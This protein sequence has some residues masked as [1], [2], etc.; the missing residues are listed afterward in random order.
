MTND[1]AIHTIFIS[2]SDDDDLQNI[3]FGEVKEMDMSL[4]DIC[5]ELKTKI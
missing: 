2:K 3:A 4:E 5:I 1:K